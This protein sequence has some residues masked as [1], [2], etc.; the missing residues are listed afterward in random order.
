MFMSKRIPNETAAADP[1]YLAVANRDE[2]ALGCFFY[3][4]IT[5]GI[6]CLPTCASRLAKPENVRY[7]PTAKAA[8][9]A[10][11]RPCKRCQPNSATVTA[12]PTQRI[13]DLCRYIE[14]AEEP[15]TLQRLAAQVGYSRYHLHRVFH[16]IVGITPKAYAQAVRNQR[17][18]QTLQST[19]TITEAL[20]KAGF[21]S[22]A[23]FYADTNEILGMTAKQFKNGG[24]AVEVVFAVAQCHLGAVLV[25]RSA[26]GICT[27]SLGDDPQQL[28][29]ELQQRFT[30]ATLLAGNAQFEQQ[31]AQV[32]G[33]LENPEQGLDLPLDIRG[34]AFQ[35][36]VWT[37]LCKIPPGET[38][39]YRQLAERIGAPT[40]ARAVA[41]ACAKNTL[42]V[43]IP[44]H[45]IVRQDGALSGYRWGVERKRAL[46]DCERQ[47][48]GAPSDDIV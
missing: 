37:A 14:A 20:H 18:R 4:V 36:R 45:R 41:K 9:E 23:R 35:H 29:V 26:R 42:A 15:P 12:Q 2:R 1:R 47:N 7:Y 31:I 8:E 5:T 17:V 43:A 34:T 33:F 40:S 25:A 22:T 48:H 44:C 28:V 30:A 11:F 24:S 46:L 10:G 13:A 39:S 27:I 21:P 19:S 38:L 3:A 6:Y 16:D 32:I